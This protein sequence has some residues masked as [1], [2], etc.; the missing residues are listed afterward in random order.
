MYH[1]KLNSKHTHI[2]SR[3]LNWTEWIAYIYLHDKKI[4]LI[5]HKLY[6]CATL[7]V[8]PPIMP[9]DDDYWLPLRPRRQ[10]NW[11]SFS[12]PHQMIYRRSLANPS[13]D[14][15]NGEPISSTAAVHSG[16]YCNIYYWLLRCRCRRCCAPVNRHKTINIADLVN[17][18]VF[19]T[20]RTNRSQTIETELFL[21]WKR[22]ACR[23]YLWHKWRAKNRLADEGGSFG[24]NRRGKGRGRRR[25]VR[26]RTAPANGLSKWMEVRYNNIINM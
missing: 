22:L 9:T 12:K 1:Q 18:F 13:I 5:N 4:T 17:T 19:P 25:Q 11:T 21:R 2:L 15:T 16:V 24:W 8:L 10:T 23:T 14:L 3:P 7:C 26:T 20:Y 6:W